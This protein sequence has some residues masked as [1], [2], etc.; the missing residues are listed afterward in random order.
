MSIIV[1]RHGE[2]ALNAARILQPPGTPLSELGIAQARALAPR[3]A[4]L[5]I[6]AIICSDLPRALMTAAPLAELTGLPIERTDLL[7]ERNFG[8][9]RGLPFD[10]LDYNPIATDD[11]PPGG[12]SSA[13]FNERVAR[14]F[15]FVTA[16]RARVGGPLAVVT[17]GLV[18]RSILERHAKAGAGIALPERLS[19]TSVSVLA[20]QSPW[21]ILLANCTAHLDEAIRDDGRGV[22]GI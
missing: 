16:M 21:E 11:A 9:L 13:V 14:A 19:N 6:A 10:S 18:V 15:A 22:S 2:T 3:I 8:D 12:E 4:A 17:H 1:I 7:Q 5:G 20:P